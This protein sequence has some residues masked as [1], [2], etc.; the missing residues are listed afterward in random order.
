M[1]EIRGTKQEREARRM[2][3]A[4][5]FEKGETTSDISAKLG[6]TTGAVSQW[7]SIWNE[8][9]KEGLRSKAH[10]GRIPELDDDDR[11]QLAKYLAEGPKAHGFDSELWTLPRVAELIKLKFRVNH[12]P[13][14]VSR[15]L[16]QMNWS[17]Q[18]PEKRAKEQDRDAVKKWREEQWPEIKKAPRLKVN[19]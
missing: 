16:K 8:S 17:P 5:L 7:R 1:K 2:L 15:I 3:A 13:S 10:P 6:V 11:S 9:G 19:H 14:H 12:H 18:K 4:N